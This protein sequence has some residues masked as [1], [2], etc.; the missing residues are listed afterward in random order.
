MIKPETNEQRLQHITDYLSK[1]HDCVLSTNHRPTVLQHIVKIE[2][3]G[4]D[5]MSKK[6]IDYLWK[7][8]AYVTLIDDE[9]K[10]IFYLHM[11]KNIHSACMYTSGIFLILLGLIIQMISFTRLTQV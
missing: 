4:N 9:D 8:G 3:R 1:K 6:T 11:N 2:H 5:L 7:R 10:P